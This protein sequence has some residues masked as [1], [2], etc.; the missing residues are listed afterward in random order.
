MRKI[1]SAIISVSL[2][3]P[4][5][6][7]ALETAPTV[8]V[9]TALDSIVNWLFTILLVVAVVFLVLAA[10]NFVT[11]GGSEEKVTTARSQVMYAL[12]GVMVALLAR[13][14]IALVRRIVGA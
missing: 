2:L 12:I 5:I 1:I 9:M 8:D 13:G 4:L 11:A 10:F 14:L 7:L 3:L 6:G